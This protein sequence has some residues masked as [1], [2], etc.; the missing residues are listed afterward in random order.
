MKRDNCNEVL[1]TLLALPSLLDSVIQY[2]SS[3]NTIEIVE[4]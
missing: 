4:A 1:F 3:E 2:G